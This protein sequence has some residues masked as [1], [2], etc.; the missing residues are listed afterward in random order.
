MTNIKSANDDIFFKND[1][2]VS[3]VEMQTKHIFQNYLC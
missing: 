1:L 2:I 3:H